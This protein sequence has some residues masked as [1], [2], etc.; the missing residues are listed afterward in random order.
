MGEFSELSPLS[1]L[2]SKPSPLGGTAACTM[3]RR[4]CLPLTGD[5]PIS[6]QRRALS[7]VLHPLLGNIHSSPLSQITLCY[8]GLLLSLASS[9]VLSSYT[10]AIAGTRCNR[11][12]YPIWLRAAE[13]PLGAVCPEEMV[14][15]KYE[16]DSPNR[17]SAAG[18]NSSKRQG[19]IR[20]DTSA[21]NGD[22]RS[23]SLHGGA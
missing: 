14:V 21:G 16:P 3:H 10:H 23:C 8:L 19:S 22:G 13:M 5:A 20:T 7:S 4:L 9:S 2:S 15:T 18:K 11:L 1:S 6:E 17:L 12:V